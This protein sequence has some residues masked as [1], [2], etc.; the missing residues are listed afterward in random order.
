LWDLPKR[1][2]AEKGGMTEGDA[3]RVIEKELTVDD[4]LA[5]RELP[6]RL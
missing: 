3:E 6:N 2:K 4:G 5:S 1:Q